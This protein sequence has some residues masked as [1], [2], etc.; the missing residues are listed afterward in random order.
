LLKC[1]DYHF[2]HALGIR[3]NIV[4]PESQ[5]TKSPGPQ[6]VITRF[7]PQVLG[8]LPAIDLNNQLAAKAC[9]VNDIRSDRH[10]SLEVVSIEAM[11]SQS[12]PHPTLC[13]GKVAS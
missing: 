3:Q 13:I 11:R 8:M 9:K 12:I 6:I 4:V 7:V 5:Y 10:L 2:R 1:A